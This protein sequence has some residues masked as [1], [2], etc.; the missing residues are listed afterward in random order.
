MDGLDGVRWDY[1]KEFSNVVAAFEIF[2]SVFERE[3]TLPVEDHVSNARAVIPGI[4]RYL[5]PLYQQ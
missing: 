4:L 1:I 3:E 2:S 5:R